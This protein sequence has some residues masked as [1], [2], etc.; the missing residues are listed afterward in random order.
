MNDLK[1]YSVI[2]E[3]VNGSDDYHTDGYYY[4]TELREYQLYLLE[5]EDDH[6][7]VEDL[8]G[9]EFSGSL[10]DLCEMATDRELILVQNSIEKVL[11][12]FKNLVELSI[13]GLI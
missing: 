1:I 7:T 5:K 12:H 10:D 4:R 11:C 3:L 13:L 6:Y 2:T 8:N 9:E